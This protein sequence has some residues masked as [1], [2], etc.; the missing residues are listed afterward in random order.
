MVC[1]LV[2]WPSPLF[3]KKHGAIS[4]YSYSISGDSLAAL[5][6]RSRS[7]KRSNFKMRA[8]GGPLVHSGP[9]LCALITS[10]FPSAHVGN[11]LG[12]VEMRKDKALGPSI[13]SGKLLI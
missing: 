5:W 2:S 10:I 9:I 4:L 13:A 1:S 11:H 8:R 3:R 6:I 12:G 7:V